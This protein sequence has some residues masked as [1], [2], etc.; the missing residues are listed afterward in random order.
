MSSKLNLTTR[1]TSHGTDKSKNL[2]ELKTTK[3]SEYPGKPLHITR[4]IKNQHE[5]QNLKPKER[6]PVKTMVSSKFSERLSQNGNEERGN[7]V[8]HSVSHKDG[9]IST[10]SDESLNIS[11][12][13]DEI[14]FEVTK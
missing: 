14:E 9:V 4:I 3:K 12:D 7:K 2:T 1:K 5:K 10:N 6:V 11:S 8:Y 13:G